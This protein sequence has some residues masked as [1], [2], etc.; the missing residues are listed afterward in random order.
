MGRDCPFAAVPSS[1]RHEFDKFGVRSQAALQHAVRESRAAAPLLQW[2]RFDH[3]SKV[4]R[5][6]GVRLTTPPVQAG[7]PLYCEVRTITAFRRTDGEKCRGR[8]GRRAHR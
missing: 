6:S 3:E 8:E 1:F 4:W 5:F 7:L 2:Q